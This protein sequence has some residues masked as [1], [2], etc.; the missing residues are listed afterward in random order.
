MVAR[1]KVLG[2]RTLGFS[3]VDVVKVDAVELS[4]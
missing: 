3:V 2:T 4:G 1:R